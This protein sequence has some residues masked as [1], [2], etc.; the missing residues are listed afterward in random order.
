M[1]N[2]TFD[3]AIVSG[4]IIEGNEESWA[5]DE[6]E[7]IGDVD[8][9]DL[10]TDGMGTVYTYR[11]ENAYVHDNTHS[12]SG[13]DPL[14]STLDQELGI[15]LALVFG[16][17][18]IDSLLYDTIGESSFSHRWLPWVRGARKRCDYSYG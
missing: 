13:T 2:G 18:P 7:L 8:D 16:E 1:D 11:G 14:G 3:S 4:L 10:P 12:G 15:L 6:A 17:T 9:L 5:L